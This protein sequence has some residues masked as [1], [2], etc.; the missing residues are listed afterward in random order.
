MK[1]PSIYSHIALALIYAAGHT[2]C[3]ATSKLAGSRPN[4]VF[5]MIDDLGAESVGSYGSESYAT[6]AM[7]KLATQGIKFEN[8]FAQP[9]CQISRATLLSGKYGFRVGFPGNNDRALNS[10]DGW[11]KGQPT[12]ANLLQDA[13]YTTAISG[14]W[15]LAHLDKH[16]NHLTEQGF[17]YQNVW[18]HIVDG[19]RTRRYWETTYYR[20]K[21]FITDPPGAFGPDQ[22]CKYVTDFMAKHKDDEKPFFVYYPMVLVH[23]PF[24]QTPDN[25]KDPQPDW[26]AEDNLRTAEN[27]KWS[28]PNYKS[29]VEYTDK[30]IGRVAQQIDDLGIAENTLLIVTSDN[31]SYY[32]T[33]S[34]YQGQELR[35]QKGA[36]TDGGTRVP[37]IAYWKGKIKPGTLNQ[38]LMD[39]TD[40]LPT[41]VE[42]GGGKLPEDKELDG[43]SFLGQLLSEAN[44]PVRKWVFAGNKR[45]AMIRAD[46]FSLD[47]AGQLF[48]LRENH[49]QPKHVPKNEFTEKH[50][51]YH[52]LLSEAMDSL[53]APFK[54]GIKLDNGER[55]KKA[56]NNK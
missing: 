42:L 50:M 28:A 33:K 1:I 12:I 20:E 2:V 43:Q 4:I 44:A 18:A 34:N 30:L 35:G 32:R 53:N 24:P 52:K 54:E 51:T 47:A 6:P 25:I 8:A 55:K 40:L 26:T 16:P 3:H 37:F 39:F 14:K 46:D 13:G 10:K 11:G 5:V 56:K 29:M 23:F 45:K 49:Y 15:H 38:N 31:G 22:F 9:M 19:K 48:D 21:K 17:E 36:V 27:S 41:L 7:D